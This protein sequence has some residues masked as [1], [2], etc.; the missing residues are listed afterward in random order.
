[1]NN[2]LLVGKRILVVEDEMLVM[3]SIEYML[4]ELGGTSI[5]MAATVDQAL[6]AIAQQVFDVAMLDLNLDGNRSYSVAKSLSMHEIPF[7][8]S[9][10]YGERAIDELYR[11]RPVLNKPYTLNQL[12]LALTTLLASP[13][14]Q[15]VS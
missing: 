1:M 4:S 15:T 2:E 5:T 6:G 11:Q 8:F 7:A 9:T 12:N 3:M 10:G 13:T 14:S